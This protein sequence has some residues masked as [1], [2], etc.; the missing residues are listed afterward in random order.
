MP[1]RYESERINTFIS[2]PYEALGVR[3]FINCCGTR[4]VHGGSLIRSEIRAAMTA[5]SSQFVNL[6][7][8]MQQAR[9]RIAEL[10]GAEDGIVTSGSAAAIAIATCAAIAEND[11]VRMLRL[12]LTDG[13]VNKVV[14]LKGH[15]F[16]Y[17]QAIRMVGGKII[18]VEDLSDLDALDFDSVALIVYLGTRDREAEIS[19]EEFVSIGHQY[20]VPI[21]VD[22]ASEYIENPNVWLSRGADLVVYS[23]GKVLRGPQTSGLLLGRKSLIDAAWANSSPHRAFG[24]P[25]KIGKEDIIGVIAALEVW[26]SRDKAKALEQWESDI[27]KIAKVINAVPG[28]CVDELPPEEGDIAP[29]VRVRWD[30]SK[31]TLHGLELRRRLLEGS[32]RIMVDDGSATANSILIEVVSLQPGEGEIIGETIAKILRETHSEKIIKIATGNVNGNWL[33]EVRFPRKPRTH[34]V[35]LIQNGSQISGHQVSEWFE[36]SISGV[37]EGASVHLEFEDIY[38]HAII[39]YQFDGEVIGDRMIGKVNL[40]SCTEHARGGTNFTQYGTVNWEA[41]QLPNSQ[42]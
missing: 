1:I 39:T 26:F 13:M 31:I 42:D 27:Q 25:M 7:D 14:M 19:F 17:D 16:P 6:N 36:G 41:K 35:L 11:P 2:N 23:G 8:L 24:R 34:R 33:F 18:D 3:P 40:G 29:Q 10:T 15:R 4:T 30:T 20:G 9:V 12:P 5:A 21:L 28:A 32:P 37:M 38:E 22:A